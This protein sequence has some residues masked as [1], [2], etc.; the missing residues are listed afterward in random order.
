MGEAEEKDEVQ[1][2]DKERLAI[3]VKTKLSGLLRDDGRKVTLAD[4]G[5]SLYVQYS[6]DPPHSR[7]Y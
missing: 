2:T 1:L 5:P 6:L 7:G 4:L 3:E